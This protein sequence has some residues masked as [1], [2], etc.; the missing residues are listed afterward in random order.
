MNSKTFYDTHKNFALR[1]ILDYYISPGTRCK[2][3]ILRKKLEKANHFP[4]ALDL[5]CSGNSFLLFTYDDQ[6]KSF[7][8]IA[9]Q[10]LTY[11]LKLRE[12]F[13][14][15]QNRAHLNY[16]PINADISHLPYRSRSFDLI[17][18]LDVL[19][20]SRDD[21]SVINEISRILKN[22]GYL[23]LTIPHQM[24]YFDEQDKIIGHYRRYELPQLRKIFF[25]HGYNIIRVFG[26]YGQL[27]KISKVQKYDPGQIEE[28]IISLRTLYQS[29]SLFRNVWKVIVKIIA[30][31]M[32]FDARFQPIDR[33]LNIGLVLQKEE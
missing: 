12:K 26:V 25:E 23:I 33:I 10:P 4:N 14:E 6:H 3:D 9:E 20:H 17:S 16:H 2:Y 11:Y 22:K 21:L 29:S 24:K 5:G 31:F 18:A 7:L 28:N 30:L 27:F 19:E 13:L 8:D 32:R 1:T 15:S